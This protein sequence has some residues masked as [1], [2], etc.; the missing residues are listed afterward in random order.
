MADLKEEYGF[1]GDYED[2]G[3]E[4]QETGTN[5]SNTVKQKQKLGDQQAVSNK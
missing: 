3:V 2:Y 1:N 4:S 5:K